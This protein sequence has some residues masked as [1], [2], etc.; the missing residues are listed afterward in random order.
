MI[1]LAAFYSWHLV[2]DRGFYKLYKGSEIVFNRDLQN[3]PGTGKF[4]CYTALSGY[5][6]SSY[7]QLLLGHHVDTC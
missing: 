4:R 6:G 3:K 2:P 5:E 1:D 7:I